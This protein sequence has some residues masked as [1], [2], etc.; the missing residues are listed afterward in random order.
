M[1]KR[2]KIALASCLTFSL[3]KEGVLHVENNAIKPTM[4]GSDSLLIVVKDVFRPLERKQKRL[5]RAGKLV[6][7]ISADDFMKCGR[8][9]KK[10]F[11]PGLFSVYSNKSSS[12][13]KNRRD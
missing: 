13:V 8:I 3:F 1:G 10:E 9:L 2:I 7:P 12:F 4:K 11:N 5:R 6:A